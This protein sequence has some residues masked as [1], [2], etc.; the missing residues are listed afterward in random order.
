MGDA[1]LLEAVDSAYRQARAAIAQYQLPEARV[2]LTEARRLLKGLGA[3]ERFE[4]DVRIRLTESWLI[5]DDLGLGAALSHLSAARRD[6]ESA[7]RDDLRSLAHLQ[8]GVLNARAGHIEDA[9][10]QLRAAVEVAVGLPAEDRVRLLINK[11]TIGAQAGALSE[12]AAD[13]RAAVGLATD[14]PQYRFMATH[15]LGFV[16]YLRGDLPAALRWMAE[17]DEMGGGVD[18]AVARL[19]RGRVLM[20][21]GLVEDAAPLL[22]QAAV[23]MRAAH[24][25]EELAD[26]MLEQ[27]RCALLRGDTGDAVRLVDELVSNDA[28]RGERQR[29]LDARAVRL[30]ALVNATATSPGLVQEAAE[31]ARSAA[32]AGIAWV[33]DRATASWAI[34]A[35]GAGEVVDDPGVVR[36]LQ[37]MRTSPYL[38]TRVL[39]I[40]AQLS[41]PSTAGRR[42]HLVRAAARDVAVARAGMSSL[43]L[44]TALAIH[45]APLMALDMEHAVA[46]GRAWVA[47]SAMERW[48]TALDSVPSV[49]PSSNPAVAALW[50]T[51]RQRHEDLRS[52]PASGAQ[53][54]LLQ[55]SGIESQLREASWAHG[56][57]PAVPRHAPLRR[58]DVGAATVLSYAVVAGSVWVVV[59]S[60]SVRAQLLR[61]GDRDHTMDLVART[62]ADAHAA[63]HAPHG[64]LAAGI[65]SSL[66]AGL[67]Q[68][69]RALLPDLP[70][71]PVVIVPGGA[72][73]HLPWGM[74]PRLRHRSV[75]LSR[76]V[77][78]WRDGLTLL[79][80]TPAVAVAV[81]PGLGLGQREGDGV[82]SSWVNARQV[83]GE[84]AAVAAA[85][86]GNDVVHV[87]AHG[88]HRS[89]NPLFSSL[90]L[91]GG[92]LFAHELEGLP[93]GASLV[94]LSA[95]SAGRAR[96]RPGD[97]A[98]GLTSSLL[99]MGVRSVVAP[100]TDVPDEVAC[101]TM[102]EFHVRLAAGE[103]GP[104][105]LAA[106][107]Q[108]LLARSFTWFGSSWRMEHPG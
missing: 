49:V 108:S 23:Q 17:A 9:M 79:G 81:G 107:S 14:L 50:S 53:S 10:E 62:T 77:T 99:A 83:D 69:D 74:L 41:L 97:E 64:P 26:T 1:A 29:E 13:L 15:N 80:A 56:T 72:L 57:A 43:D 38:S 12:A 24:M 90:H 42:S 54:L 95:C 86:V 35:G 75:T 96:L 60:T 101:D 98:L 66:D 21:V 67:R 33:A 2:H 39:A 8:A 22:A 3:T 5:F 68:L 85:L 94:V 19:D 104:A 71:G 102:A 51:L 37:R 55:V 61:V 100:L 27:A 103:E 18:R 70:D 52:V 106:A 30:E 65:R 16:E 89:D 59:V 91:H 63:A 58:R 73:V 20:E 28:G 44:R 93:L 4:P 105:A 6:A 87:A 88:V 11:G 82:L 46:G 48:R 34:L 45:V 7:D 31:L 36:R 92:S 47:L 76:S 78:A 32:G 40:L 84:P 25:S